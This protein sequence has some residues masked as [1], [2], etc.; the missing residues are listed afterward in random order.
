MRPRSTIPCHTFHQAKTPANLT[1][2]AITANTAPVATTVPLAKNRKALTQR[3]MP[4]P[5]AKPAPVWVTGAVWYLQIWHYRDEIVQ[6]VAFLG[7]G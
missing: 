2:G 6:K 5:Q 1:W 7:T 3:Q 4:H